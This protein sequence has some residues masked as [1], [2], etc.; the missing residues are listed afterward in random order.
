MYNLTISCLDSC[1]DGVNVKRPWEDFGELLKQERQ[2]HSLTQLALAKL[3][4][5]SSSEISRWE[6]GERRPKQ[7]SL[8]SLSNIFTIPIQVLQTRAGYT[9]EFDWYRSFSAP[10][11]KKEDILRTATETE[12]DELRQHLIYLRFRASTLEVGHPANRNQRT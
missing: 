1:T 9:P 3:L 2:R 12:K 6:K 4:D 7:P 11:Q 8:L 10:T 5:K